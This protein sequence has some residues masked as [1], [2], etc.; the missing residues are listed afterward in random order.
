[1]AG[2][3]VISGVKQ[4][5]D[6]MKRASIKADVAVRTSL[7]QMGQAVVRESRAQ[8]TTVV[9]DKTG[10]Q[11]VLAKGGKKMPGEKIVRRG[12]HVDGDRPHIRTGNLARSIKADPPKQIG[13][14]RFMT[15][16]GPRAAYGRRIE[17]GFTGND[18]LNRNYDQ[19]PYPYMAPGLEKARSLLAEI[20]A[21]NMRGIF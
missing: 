9:A 15:E 5:E 18:S 8:F 19:S 13:L 4:F 10:S 21:R 20:H 11:R 16:V 14:G 2:T 1:M 17:L 7:V 12:A 6:A 3:F